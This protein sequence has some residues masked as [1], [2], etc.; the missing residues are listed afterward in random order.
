[1]EFVQYLDVA[2]QIITLLGVP[3]AIYLYI[4]EQKTQREEREHDTFDS[5]DNKYI[6]LQELCL[7]YPHLDVFDT[8]KIETKP[9]TES[10]KK[11]EEAKI[12]IRISIFERSFLMYKK[13]SIKQKK[14]QWKGWDIEILE[15]FERENF[16]NVWNNHKHYYD[17]NFVKYFENKSTFLS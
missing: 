6:E 9:L 17:R 15:W 10:E 13:T 2:S 7:S 1:M 12:L 11:Q 3:T 8:K 14:V 5:L 4:K 16:N